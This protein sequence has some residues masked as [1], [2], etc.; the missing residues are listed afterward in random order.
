MRL[1]RLGALP[2]CAALVAVIAVPA[3]SEITPQAVACKVDYS[4]NDWGGG[5]TATL[6][7]N[8][9]GD[10][11]SNWSL[12][13]AFPGNQRIQL[14]GWSANWSQ[15]PNSPN[16]T[17]TNL[18]WNGTIATGASRE[19]GFNGTYS[20]SNTAP[21][22][23]SLNGV[24]CTGANTGPTVSL[25]QPVTGGTYTAGATIPLA[26]NAADP[27]GSVQRVEFY[28]GSTLIG[29]DT[30]SPYGLSWP[31]V[32][33][34]N[35]VLVARAYD[36]EGAFTNSAPVDV[37]VT[38]NTG[39]AVIA[40]TTTVSVPEGGTA[41]VAL[42]LSAQP[43]GSVT[44]NTARTTGDT[45]L[46]VSTG[47]ART[48]TTSNWNTPQ[49]V[50]LAAAQDTDT[51]NGTATF[52][53][54]ATG[55]TAA[56]I[57]ATESDDDQSA[58]AERFLE[59]YNKIKAP[60]NG[61]FSSHNPPIPYHSVETL[62]VEAPD[63]GH[64]TTSEAYSYWIWLEAQY[65]QATADWSRFNQA[66][67]S[68]ETHIIPTAADQP[69][70]AAY[71]PADPAD[72]APEQDLPD[73]YPV[74]LTPSV[75]VGSD[76]LANELQ[77]TYG[78]RDIYGMHWLLDVD[79]RYGY[80]RRGN[81]TGSPSY[82]NTFQ[83]GP[84]ESVWET[85]P[86]PSW[87]SF[88]DGGPNGFLP[89]FVQDSQYAT[90][91]RYTNAPDADARAV[92]AA[93]WA[94]QW[95]TAQGNQ[96]QI[97]GTLTKAARMGD[98]LRYA[99]FD[100]YF[101]QIGNCVGPAA[102]PAG[103]GK[104]SAHYLMSWYY[105]WGGATNGS[106]AWRIG[107]SPSHF[108]Y[109]NP[110]AAYALANVPALRPQSPTAQADWTTSFTR[111]LEFYRWL[112][113]AEGGIAGGATN[114]WAGRYATPPANTSTF[115]GMFYDVQPVYHDPPS[116][117]WFGMQAWSM[118]RIAELYNQTGNATAKTL[119]DKWV[120]WAIANT[121]ANPAAGTWSIPDNLTW[122]GQPDTWNPANPGA[123]TGLHVTVATR[124]QDVGITAALAKTLIHYA[125]E[126]G[127]I[128]AR[129]MAK[130]LLDAMWATPNQTTRGISVTE[131]RGDYERF[132]N[133]VYVPPGFTGTMANGDPIN[134]SSTFGSLRSWYTDDP[135]WSKV[136]DHLSGG[137]APS[138]R[139]HRFW[140]QADVAMALAEYGRLFP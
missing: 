2:A 81:G 140:A 15:A 98:Y 65:G 130:N 66:W 22:S 64:V 59:L 114:S 13:F 136:E 112:Q 19:I 29:T 86:H 82:I 63:Y 125:S 35:Y 42:R 133:P 103:S 138:F 91:Y 56:T 48:F 30:S 78:T 31:N 36:N 77:S 94:L 24:N 23:F 109:Q 28:A 41:N 121:T 132:D 4:V 9:L 105:A 139:Y 25:T 100:K 20:G 39:P 7:I 89:L 126:S 71:N 60:A 45:D 76:P 55:Q 87:E 62:I 97:S 58:Y 26:A 128:A 96:S 27:G 53:A 104:N 99:M 70:N 14:P 95:A 33:A 49:T 46:T 21:T 83:R 54:S 50:T 118:E 107:S 38:P 34:G 52:T 116:N 123:N 85:V 67:T 115:Y 79:N 106:W 5:F 137:P 124:G 73:Q 113:S 12:G 88:N 8:N 93:Y 74:P 68:M 57:T 1:R 111:Q 61:Y 135:E 119:L 134:S 44:V 131:T 69:S 92:Q 6:K 16:V 127:N 84:Q 40:E 17:A 51:A 90:Q 37:T 80:G 122:S 108:G 110:L 120:P 117:R 72:Y 11:V 10:P 43:S 102:C 75:P 18:G 129:D 3:S 47:A 32:A 101:K